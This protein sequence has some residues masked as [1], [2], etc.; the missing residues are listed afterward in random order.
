MYSC[1][2]IEDFSASHNRIKVL[3]SSVGCLSRLATLCLDEN[4][5]EEIP[6]EVQ[7]CP[8]AGM[9][10]FICLTTETVLP[11]ILN[12]AVPEV[13]RGVWPSPLR[14]AGKSMHT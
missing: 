10:C 8:V 12:F 7:C 11:P 3:P 4:E 2:A 6:E 13:H 9:C 1:T 5:L 14:V